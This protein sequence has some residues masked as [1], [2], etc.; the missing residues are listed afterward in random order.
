MYKMISSFG[1]LHTG[2]PGAQEQRYLADERDDPHYR[3][4]QENSAV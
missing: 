3:G 4:M 2:T 1:L